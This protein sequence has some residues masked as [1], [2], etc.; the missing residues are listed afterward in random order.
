PCRRS[1]VGD[2]IAQ[3]PGRP[4]NHISLTNNGLSSPTCFRTSARPRA[5]AGHP[6]RRGSAWKGSWGFSFPVLV[7]K[8][9]QKDFHRRA[10]AGG[11][12]PSG[13]A[14]ASSSRR[15]RDCSVGWIDSGES[16]GQRPLATG[17]FRPQKKG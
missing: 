17:R 8:I 5:E 2:A 1:H 4:R 10:L 6:F 7:G 14:T 13:L 16:T 9:Y 15:G 3:G 11:G 12:W